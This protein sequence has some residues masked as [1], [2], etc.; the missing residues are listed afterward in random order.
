MSAIDTPACAATGALVDGVG[1][2]CSVGLTFSKTPAFRNAACVAFWLAVIFWSF[3]LFAP[4]NATVAAVLFVCT[5]SVA[6]S[7]FLI[8]ELDSPYG[9]V[10]R[11]SDTPLRFVLEQLG[12]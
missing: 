5:L 1:C 2:A 12:R 8:L 10:I 9:G 3:G 6:A 7:I 11:I 4:R